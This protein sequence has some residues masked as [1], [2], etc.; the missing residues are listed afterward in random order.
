MHKRVQSKGLGVMERRVPKS[1][2]YAHIKSAIDS[3]MTVNKIKYV[4]SREYAKRR[5][6]IFF[7]VT[8]SQLFE[9]L[10]EYENIGE[11]EDIGATNMKG[12][13]NIV[14]HTEFD[15][16]PEYNRPYLILD[17]RE[18]REYELCQISQARS[19]PHP[20]LRR[21]QY[22]PDIH[23]FKNK[24]ETLIIVYCNDERIS[25][26]GAKI[27]VDRGFDNIFVLNGGLN[28]FAVDYPEFI[29]G[30][31]LEAAG[32]R[33]SASRHSS[34]SRRTG[35]GRSSGG[36]RRNNLG[37]IGEEDDDYYPDHHR[38]S[39]SNK[40]GYSPSDDNRLTPRKLDR[41]NR[42]YKLQGEGRSSD[43]SSDRGSY[44]SGSPD[45][46][47]HKYHEYSSPA[48]RS[49]ARSQRGD[50]YSESGVT[51]GSNMSVAESV[52]SRASARKGRF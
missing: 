14:S 32:G 12:G 47:S 4:T 13:L 44:G 41:H 45:R 42:Q 34:Q 33:S 7:R 27:L 10:S 15:H 20:L 29:D 36:Y 18:A 8:T 23:K 24:P 22:H 6:E 28:E 16:K 50:T 9:L 2:K 21:D 31:P 11:V 38:N 5:G 48:R 26:E 39:S 19:F 43:K 17:L 30:T 46:H 35:Q 3:G 49:Q 1:E 52:I 51:V 37:A 25:A 40:Y